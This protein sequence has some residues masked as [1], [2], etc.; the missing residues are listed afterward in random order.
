MSRILKIFLDKKGGM[1]FLTSSFGACYFLISN[2][3]NC[4]QILLVFTSFFQ[5]CVFQT[6]ESGFRHL[7]G[8]F[9]TEKDRKQRKKSAIVVGHRFFG[10]CQKKKCGPKK[11]SSIFMSKKNYHLDHSRLFKK[12]ILLISK[13]SD[14]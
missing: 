10:R 2:S 6:F 7:M 9:V 1:G 11:S 3:N 12:R 13:L 8:F 14:T 5:N 4:E